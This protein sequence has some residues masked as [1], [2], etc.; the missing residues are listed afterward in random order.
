MS[1]EN[2]NKT[3]PDWWLKMPIGIGK[4]FVRDG[5]ILFDTAT[6]NPPL[7]VPTA[8]CSMRALAIEYLVIHSIEVQAY[9]LVDG[10]FVRLEPPSIHQK[11]SW[12]LDISNTPGDLYQV[13]GTPNEQI[14]HEGMGLL[15]RFAYGEGTLSPV[16]AAPGSIVSIV[17]TQY[18]PAAGPVI[19]ANSKLTAVMTGYRVLSH[20]AQKIKPSRELKSPPYSEPKDVLTL[21]LAPGAVPPSDVLEN[22]TR[23][24]PPP[25]FRINRRPQRGTMER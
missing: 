23:I 24:Y 7:N 13:T 15:G 8:L 16:I 22:A 25:G 1:Y 10:N 6:P 18:A 4:S 12:K 19:P 3:H 2:L 5:A 11:L 9:A 17:V 20:D 14:Q 21:H